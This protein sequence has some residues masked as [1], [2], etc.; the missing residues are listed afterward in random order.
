MGKRVERRREVAS[1][2]CGDVEYAMEKALGLASSGGRGK[3]KNRPKNLL[4]STSRSRQ[5]L[6][7]SAPLISSE[8]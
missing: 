1:D 7:A 5:R 6:P 8:F 3:R 4:V 2:G